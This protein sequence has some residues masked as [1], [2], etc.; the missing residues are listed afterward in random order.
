MYAKGEREGKKHEA[1]ELKGPIKFE[2]EIKASQ[3]MEFMSVY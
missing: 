3:P 1:E 2:N